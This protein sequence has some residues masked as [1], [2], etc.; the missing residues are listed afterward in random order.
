MQI[1]NKQRL[2]FIDI[3]KGIGILLV[4]FQHCLGG[5]TLTDT[6]PHTSKAIA[7][8]YMPLFFFISVIYIH[9][10][11]QLNSFIVKLNHY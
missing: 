11:I 5:G 7:S 10:R 4:I 1:A 3:A 6:L 8:F 2:E 9:L